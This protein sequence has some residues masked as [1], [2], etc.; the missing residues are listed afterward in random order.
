MEM[1]RFDSRA[2]K[3]LENAWSRTGQDNSDL[4]R[5]YGEIL[6]GNAQESDG[7][8]QVSLE[9][10]LEARIR[11]KKSKEIETSSFAYESMDNAGRALNTAE[12]VLEQDEVEPFVTE[13]RRQGIVVSALHNHWLFEEPR[14]LYVHFYSIEPPLEFAEKVAAALKRLKR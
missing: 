5:C 4:C 1:G 13:L 9:R 7:A 12:A 3:A 14:L 11:N 8:C 6:G 2:G 10:R